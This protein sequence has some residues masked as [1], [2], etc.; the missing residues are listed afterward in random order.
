MA[1]RI[2]LLRANFIRFLKSARHSQILTGA[3]RVLFLVYDKS[4]ERR[5]RKQI[6][7]FESE[8]RTHGYQVHHLDLTADFAV[9]L[10]VHDYRESYYEEP[11]DLEPAFED[12]EAL[13]ANRI[14]KALQEFG[15]EQR[16]V[17]I[18]SGVGN[19]FGLIKVSKVLNRIE[20]NVR[21][22]L[23]VFFPGEYR[24]KIYRLFD[25]RDGW[26]YHAIPITA[27]EE[28]IFR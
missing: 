15:D 13:I 3:E 2:D 27:Q 4:D 22:Y 9:W 26:N 5:L 23:A 7:E 18:L 8:A 21:G 25:A 17:L 24:D 6:P 20:E 11:A 1:S 16:S 19:F 28:E 14:N 12:L 10:S